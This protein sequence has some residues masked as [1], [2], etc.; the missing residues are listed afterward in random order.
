[1]RPYSS[2]HSTC[3]FAAPMEPGV[4]STDAIVT[5]SGTMTPSILPPAL[6]FEELGLDSMQQRMFGNEA[7]PGERKMDANES[8]HRPKTPPGNPRTPPG[9]PRSSS[10]NGHGMPSDAQ[11][12][13]TPRDARVPVTPGDHLPL[14]TAVR[15]RATP[16]PPPPRQVGVATPRGQPMTP[17]GQSSGAMMTPRAG[18]TPSTAQSELLTPRYNSWPASVKRLASTR[19]RLLGQRKQ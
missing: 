6:D 11:I 5:T 17:R 1:M 2:E 18:G 12:P 10:I 13:A 16:P 7:C 4:T 15:S 3:L 14:P 9:N 8:E 19:Y